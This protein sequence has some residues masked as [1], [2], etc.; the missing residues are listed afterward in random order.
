[1]SS[2]EPVQNSGSLLHPLDVRHMRRFFLPHQQEHDQRHKGREQD[3]Q[4]KRGQNATVIRRGNNHRTDADE[5][6][7]NYDNREHGFIH[8]LSLLPLSIIFPTRLR[9]ITSSTNTLLDYPSAGARLFHRTEV[10]HKTRTLGI[11]GTHGLLAANHTS[12][13][14]NDR[15]FDKS[16]MRFLTARWR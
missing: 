3:A 14:L 6:H 9:H 15:G 4:E 7:Q 16:A 1:M 2:R 5:N 13:A 11:D 8:D 10:P 12:Y